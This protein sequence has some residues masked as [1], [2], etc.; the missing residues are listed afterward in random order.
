MA[1]IKNVVINWLNADPKR[2]QQYK[3]QGRRR[4]QVTMLTD[5]KAEATRWKSEYGFR[6]TPVESEGK[7]QYQARLSRK[8]YAALEGSDGMADDLTKPQERPVS[9]IGA[10]GSSIDPNT[11][12]NG[13]V[14][15]VS[16]NVFTRPDGEV[17]RTLKAIMIRRWVQR[18]PFEDEDAFDLD[19]KLE[20]ITED[21]KGSKEDDDDNLFND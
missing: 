6:V 2:P 4:W 11:V 14:G 19:G 8:A 3:G 13:S 21:S 9:V 12:G 16:F 20:V 18:K 7:L 17:F 1:V 5:N 10:D 15:D